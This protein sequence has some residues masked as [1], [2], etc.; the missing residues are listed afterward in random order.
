MAS[1]SGI[2]E[3]ISRLFWGYLF[4]KLLLKNKNGYKIIMIFIAI[5]LILFIASW[6]I[7]NLVENETVLIILAFIWLI[8]LYTLISGALTLLPIQ[9][10]HIYGTS[11]GGIV[12]GLLYCARIGGTLFSIT[13]VIQTRQLLGWFYMNL[14]WVGTQCILFVL[15]ITSK[16]K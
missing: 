16:S 6:T 2:C 8:V 4:D 3:G 1:I 9:T 5:G 14:F 15:V 10:A 7:L 11:K 12:Y 13:A